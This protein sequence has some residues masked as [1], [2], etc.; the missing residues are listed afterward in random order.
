[1]WMDETTFT[2]QAVPPKSWATRER[3][4]N[5]PYSGDRQYRVTV[6][7]A[8]GAC[9]KKPVY[10]LSYSTC[11][12]EYRKFVGRIHRALR[13]RNDRPLL[14][15]DGHPAH[16]SQVSVDKVSEHFRPLQACPYSSNFNRKLS[17]PSSGQQQQQQQKLD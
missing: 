8:I 2:S 1:M 9:L 15:Y 11:G 7:G 17:L 16:T 12:V 5:H 6:Y 13:N 14:Y 10:Y 4:N 3:P